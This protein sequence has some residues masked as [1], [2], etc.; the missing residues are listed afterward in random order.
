MPHAERSSP[1]PH[2]D[3]FRLHA[4][5]G[6][7]LH[8]IDAARPLRMPL[9]V[10]FHE[11]S[12]HIV[13]H[14]SRYALDDDYRPMRDAFATRAPLREAASRAEWDHQSHDAYLARRDATPARRIGAEAASAHFAPVSRV[15]KFIANAHH[16]RPLITTIFASRIIR[17]AAAPMMSALR[18]STATHHFPRLRS[19]PS[20]PPA[21]EIHLASFDALVTKCHAPRRKCY[22]RARAR[23]AMPG[24]MSLATAQ[25]QS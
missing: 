19:T 14:I 18:I 3:Y 21:E 7:S 5:R 11:F 13:S 15:V 9:A 24:P 6:G 2:A 10:T 1:R 8:G 23:A 17:R 20:T 4:T 22:R 12:R 25:R 16:A